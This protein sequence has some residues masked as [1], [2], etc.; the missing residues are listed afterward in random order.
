[1]RTH[2]AVFPFAPLLAASIVIGLPSGA[3]SQGCMPL[4]F[5]SPSLAGLKSSYLDPHE[6]QL[7]I[8]GRRV[9]T[10]KF[11]AGTQPAPDQAPGGQPLNLH[12]NSIDLSLTYGLSS[13]LSVA[14]TVPF[15]YS[16]ASNFYPDGQRHT[17]SSG[18]IGDI[19]AVASYWILDPGSHVTGN[20]GVGLGVK[21]NTGS[22]H[23]MDSFWLPDGVIQQPVPQTIQRGD[24]GWAILAQGQA[25][26]RI[27]GQVSGYASGQYSASLK[28]HTDVLW[29]PANALWAVPDVYSARAGLS[30]AASPQN[31][32]SFSGGWRVDGTTVHDI[33]HKHGDYYRHAGY[34][35]YIEPGINWVHGADQF[36]LDVPIRV[37]QDYLSMYTSTGLRIGTGGVNDYVVYAS[38]SRRF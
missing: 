35:M 21:S 20:V 24:G 37:R 33:F 12:L 22:N 3:S 31:G 26:Q 7:S 1:V 10:N 38:Y 5:T 6:W 23:A 30:W 15:S 32:I 18:G 8:S 16:T 14:A 9:A 11:Y 28:Q 29:P 34:T 19:N 4:R 36:T 25:F 27:A 13:R 2:F 17:V